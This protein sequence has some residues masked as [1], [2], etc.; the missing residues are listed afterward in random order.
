MSPFEIKVDGGFVAVQPIKKGVVVIYIITFV[1][2][3]APLAVNRATR[4]EGGFFWTSIPEGR[5]AEAESI[6]REIDKYLKEKRLE[7]VLL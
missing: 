4:F 3:R 5:Q 1:D 2:G 7:N 6:G